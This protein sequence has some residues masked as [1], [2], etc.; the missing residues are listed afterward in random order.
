MGHLCALVGR[1]RAFCDRRV[2]ERFGDRRR[3]LVSAIIGASRVEQIQA[4][5]NASGIKLTAE[6]LAAGPVRDR[7]AWLILRLVPHRHREAPT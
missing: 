1:E 6:T 3:E 5:G 7:V 2:A 4:N